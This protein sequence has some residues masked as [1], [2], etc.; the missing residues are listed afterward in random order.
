MRLEGDGMKTRTKIAL[1]LHAALALAAP[2]AAQK[3]SDA[4]SRAV[5][6]W[7]GEYQPA[8]RQAL[9]RFITTRSADGTFVLHARMYDNGRL[10][11]DLRNSGL[12]GVS[13]GMYFTVTT[14]VNDRRTEART[15][16]VINAYLVQKLDGD[17]FE[18]VHV[19]SG[20]RFRVKRVEAGS[21]R[22]PD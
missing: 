2:A 20:N 13:N 4:E 21:V 17:D 5:G 8:P 6:T 22:L 7:Y 11:A 15:P 1:A 9:Q 18:Y 3:H 10:V 19:A 12:W 16:E 14:E